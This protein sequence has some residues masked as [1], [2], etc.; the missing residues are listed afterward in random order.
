M[1]S[2][3]ILAAATAYNADYPE[4]AAEIAAG[5]PALHVFIGANDS[6]GRSYR[7]VVSPVVVLADGGH[8]GAADPVVVMVRRR[9]GRERMADRAE[10]IARRTFPT[11]ASIPVLVTEGRR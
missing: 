5:T 6:L 7:F 9:D 11:D 3:Q 4:A 2:A 10:T 1:N 8:A